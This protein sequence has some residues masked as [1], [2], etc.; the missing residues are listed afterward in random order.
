VTVGMHRSARTTATVTL[1]ETRMGPIG[2]W[3]AAT[4]TV[5]LCSTTTRSCRRRGGGTPRHISKTSTPA[6]TTAIPVATSS[7][8]GAVAAEPRFEASRGIPWGVAKRLGGNTQMPKTQPT[9]PPG[10][11]TSSTHSLARLLSPTFEP[12]PFAAALSCHSDYSASLPSLR[13]GRRG[14]H[15]HVSCPQW[16]APPL[17]AKNRP[18]TNNEQ[19]RRPLRHRPPGHRICLL[20]DGR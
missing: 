17:Q 13:Q 4:R 18:S 19:V 9:P 11:H 1:D 5:E 7:Q 12:F 10:T 8:A 14:P 16:S 3:P 6:A 20:Q 2:S 15:P